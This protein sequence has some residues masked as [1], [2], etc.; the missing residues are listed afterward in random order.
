[1]T[2]INL[3]DLFGWIDWG[4]TFDVVLGAILAILFAIFVERIRKPR[5]T[6]SVGHTDIVRPTGPNFNIGDGKSLRVRVFAEPLRWGT[7]WMMR[8]HA[9]QCRDDVSF[10]HLDGQYLY[11]REMRARWAGTPEPLQV[12]GIDA[13]QQP[14]TILDP[15]KIVAPSEVDIAPSESETLDIVVRFDNDVE[16]FGW[17]NESYQYAWR[18]LVWRIPFGRYLVRVTIRSGGQSWSEVFRL[19]N[20]VPRD[21]FRLEPAIAKDRKKVALHVRNQ[22]FGR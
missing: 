13:N 10:H 18:N 14:I 21:D 15:Y 1:M 12:I 16:C 3:L 17:S 2:T 9:V 6:M 19:I 4:R 7:R 5:L 11:N 22:R 20:D 8:S